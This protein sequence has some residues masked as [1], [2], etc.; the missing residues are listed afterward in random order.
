MI[1]AIA[2]LAVR[3]AQDLLLAAILAESGRR[4]PFWQFP[5]RSGG[6]GLYT[7]LMGDTTPNLPPPGNRQAIRHP[8]RSNRHPHP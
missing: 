7:T 8:C 5:Y 4:L 3:L 1:F 2:I 6:G